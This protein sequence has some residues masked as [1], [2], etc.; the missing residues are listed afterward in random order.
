MIIEEQKL[1]VQNGFI[2]QANM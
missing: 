1:T 2:W